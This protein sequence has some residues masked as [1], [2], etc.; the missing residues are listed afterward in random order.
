[1]PEPQRQPE[2]RRHSWGEDD[3][4]QSERRKAEAEE[5]LVIGFEEQVN[6]LK[7]ANLSP[8]GRLTTILAIKA[9]MV[10]DGLI[11][12]V[13]QDNEVVVDIISQNERLRGVMNEIFR[14]RQEALDE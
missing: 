6:E 12:M 5:L 1:M 7:R 10:A 14:L 2:Q 8:G 3:A 9:R 13:M 11:W 4:A